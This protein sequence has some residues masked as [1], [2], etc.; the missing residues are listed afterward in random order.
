MKPFT[1]DTYNVNVHYDLQNIHTVV[2]AF[3]T[4]VEQKINPLLDDSN[5]EG[6][7]QVNVYGR[8]VDE[9]FLDVPEV[10]VVRGEKVSRAVSYR[11]NR[12]RQHGQRKTSAAK[13]DAAV[14]TRNTSR[15]ELLTME[16]GRQDSLEGQTKQ[17]SD[18]YKLGQALKDQL[19][20]VYKCLP[21]S[22]KR[23]I[24]E[25]EVFGILTSGLEGCV[26]ALDLPCAGVYRF[27]ELFRFTL[28][29]QFDTY[30]LLIKTLARF[31]ALKARIRSIL[32][33]LRDIDHASASDVLEEPDLF[34]S[35]R[36]KPRM[37]PT[38]ST[39]ES[40]TPLPSSRGRP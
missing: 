17:L 37:Q 9:L 2:S 14:V 25:I 32:E 40:P 24:T 34:W 35:P 1:N 36:K 12:L 15:V 29:N 10:R 26:Y 5:S 38:R 20:F 11:K 21:T 16:A 28:P 30:E 3:I 18:R 31:L 23:R 8:L 4:R 13:L 39:P 19:D 7:L 6:Y 22:Q 33:V 27:G